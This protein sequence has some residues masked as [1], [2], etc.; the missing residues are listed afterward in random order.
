M[1]ASVIQFLVRALERFTL[2]PCAMP[3]RSDLSLPAG[4]R[5]PMSRYAHWS[6]ATGYTCLPN[7]IVLPIYSPTWA[8]LLCEPT[9]PKMSKSKTA[10]SRRGRKRLRT[11][12]TVVRWS[13]EPRRGACGSLFPPLFPPSSL[14]GPESPTPPPPGGHPGGCAA[15]VRSRRVLSFWDTSTHHNVIR[16]TQKE[17]P[18]AG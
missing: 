1:T 10:N 4:Y 13:S 18:G 9:R 2:P 6:A 17:T 7:P 5:Q 3:F 12:R 16:S 11:E 15:P 14:I 8:S